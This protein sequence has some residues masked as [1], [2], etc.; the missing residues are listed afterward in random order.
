MSSS[1]S[2]GTNN[3]NI[4][5]SVVGGG[6]AGLSAAV[7]LCKNNFKVTLIES[8][9]RLGGRAYSF[10]D[11]NINEFVD[12]G[13]HIMASWYNNTYDFL[14]EIG[15]FNRLTIQKRLNVIFYDKGGTKFIFKCPGLPPPYHLIWGLF[16][17]KA[18]KWKDKTG[19]V[20]LI[21]AIKKQRYSADE[22][23][24]MTV[25]DFFMKTGQSK[26]V[27][28]Y[29]WKPFIVAVFNAR[30]EET[31]ALNFC[32]VIKKG[33]LS[34]NGT[35]LVLPK[36]DL[37][38]IYVESA[39]DYLNRAGAEILKSSRLKE[40]KTSEN[41][42]VSLILDDDREIKSDFVICAIPFYDFVSLK[43]TNKIVDEIF[44]INELV[45]SPI[46][47]IHLGYENRTNEKIFE[48]EFAGILNSSIQ[49]VFRINK[50]RICIVISR[51]DNIVDMDKEEIIELGKKELMDAIP[52]F[53][54][55]KFTYSK[56][57]KEKR[58]TF[59]PDVKSVTSR[60]GNK[61][62]LTNLFLAGDW[63]DTGLPATLESAVTSGKNCV[64]E[65]LKQT[66]I[67]N[68]TN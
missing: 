65:I 10:F 33:F 52:Q 49:W 48:H 58:A 18:L 68:N 30:P 42:P 47:N 27:I 6:I 45:N 3:S 25:T 67:F 55:V 14:E 32:E 44:K 9:P 38:K 62:R 19:I 28:D 34:K 26:R 36:E 29:F 2:P 66:K 50:S 24:R 56:V 4:R 51:A 20:K 41:K 57:V 64:N 54:N 46:V 15:T 12:N 59:L 37:N 7:F 13:Q 11:N 21:K 1:E 17:Y 23:M 53:K 60:P 63:T 16:T 39:E 35:S 5:V 43:G 40:F 8:S 31:N 61:T 22:L